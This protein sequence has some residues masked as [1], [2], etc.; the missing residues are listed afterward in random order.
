VTELAAVADQPA[1]RADAKRLVSIGIAYLRA[2]DASAAVG[3]LQAACE[4][5]PRHPVP[6]LNLGLAYKALH[7]WPRS[8][9]AFSAAWEC[10]P[11][12]VA[13]E[14]YASVLWNL[15]IV[16]SVLGDWK[17]ARA[18]WKRLGF[19]TQTG[20]S[21]PPSIPL[22]RA[23]VLMLDGDAPLFGKRL[24]PVRV[25]LDQVPSLASR[26]ELARRT[27]VHDGER[28]RTQQQ[29]GNALPIYRGLAFAPPTPR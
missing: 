23:G 24:D 3:P 18:C 25:E 8:L 1:G 5:D 17:R 13:T 29:G 14:I 22:G 2:G 16:S 9:H 10:L 15:G 19:P 6:W 12:G 27:I 20:S 26:S 11:P 28:I 7:D 4:A 21:I